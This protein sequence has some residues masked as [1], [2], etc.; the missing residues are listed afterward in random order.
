MRNRRP[1]DALQDSRSLLNQAAA[2]QK[3]FNHETHESH[4]TKGIEQNH[5]QEKSHLSVIGSNRRINCPIFLRVFR[6][7]RGPPEG[8]YG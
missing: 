1:A 2:I 4:E 7:I 8:S 6:V 3:G 5:S